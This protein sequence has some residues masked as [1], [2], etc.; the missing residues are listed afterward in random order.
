MCLREE[1]AV[2]AREEEEGAEEEK[3]E[4]EGDR[5]SPLHSHTE[6]PPSS[7]PP[8]HA[9][10]SLRLRRRDIVPRD[11]RDLSEFGAPGLEGDLSPARGTFGARV[12]GLAHLAARCE[13]APPR[14]RRPRR[15]PAG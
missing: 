7:H 4:E 1:E 5:A 3:T 6:P 10:R 11:S 2:E 13:R 15:S 8:S 14:A 12:C 9:A